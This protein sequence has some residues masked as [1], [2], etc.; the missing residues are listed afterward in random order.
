M[1][2]AETRTAAAPAE[3]PHT[4]LEV[5]D[6]EKSFGAVEVLKKVALSVDAA[7]CY[8]LVGDNGAG[9]STMLKILSGVHRPDAGE[10]RLEGRVVDFHGEIDARLAGVEMI[11]QDLA[12]CEDLDAAANIFLGRETRRGASRW[13]S[14]LNHSQMRRKAEKVLASLGTVIPVDRRVQTLSGGER[15]LVAVARALEFNPKLLLMDEPTAALSVD[16]VGTLLGL[17][18]RLKQRG[19]A[20]ILV[21]HRFTDLIQVCDSIGVLLHGRIVDEFAVAGQ[22]VDSLTTRMVRHMSGIGLEESA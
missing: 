5:K 10:I 19:V 4:V 21:S 2:L 13:F 11:F 6:I 12:L 1:A 3:T 15:Q 7:Q 22:S 8:G 17:I 16:K 20:I 14:F 18:E 9:K